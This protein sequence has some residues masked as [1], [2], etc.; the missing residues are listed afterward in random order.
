MQFKNRCNAFCAH[1]TEMNGENG[2]TEGRA[3]L[4]WSLVSVQALA[5]QQWQCFRGFKS[6]LLL[7]Y[8]TNAFALKG[9]YL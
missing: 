4:Q 6:L 7:N 2:G 8:A 5:S 1:K 9:L 3:Q